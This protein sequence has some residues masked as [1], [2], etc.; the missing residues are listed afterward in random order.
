MNNMKAVK[1]FDGPHGTAE[2]AELAAAIV[3]LAEAS[4]AAETARSAV[5]I[6]T[7]NIVAVENNLAA[8]GSS[9]EAA[10]DAH[11]GRIVSAATSGTGLPPDATVR[12]ARARET[13]AQGEVEDARA[14]LATLQE[15]LADAEYYQQ[16]GEKR[17]EEAVIAV[18][19]A[20][21]ITVLLKRAQAVQ[22]DLIARRVML[23]YLIH[24]HLVAEEHLPAVSSFMQDTELPGGYGSVY[25]TDWWKN[26]ATITWLEARE[27]LKRDPDALLPI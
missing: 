11:R 20:A 21:S 18:I 6:A 12:E 1:T 4:K 17:V 3:A 24:E 27:A 19:K 8:A 26:P 16:Q 13:D 10:R 23:R 15:A 9:V 2:R 14:V 25:L 5:R 22:T 7:A